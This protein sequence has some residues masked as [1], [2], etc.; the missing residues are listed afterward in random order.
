M[1]GSN[2]YGGPKKNTCKKGEKKAEKKGE[3]KGKVTICR[4]SESSFDFSVTK[5]SPTAGSPFESDKGDTQIDAVWRP[6]NN[7]K[8]ANLLFRQTVG[9]SRGELLT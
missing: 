3:K 5:N 2:G 6:L 4:G 7:Q 9:L 1:V 8:E